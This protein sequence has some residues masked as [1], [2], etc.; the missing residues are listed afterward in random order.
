MASKLLGRLPA[1]AVPRYVEG[2]AYALPLAA[3]SA[4][5]VRLAAR[6]LDTGRRTALASVRARHTGT[7]PALCT[8]GLVRTSPSRRAYRGHSQNTS[9]V[10]VTGGNG[11]IYI[12]YAYV[13]TGSKA[14][15]TIGNR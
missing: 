6:P 13:Q 4:D 15:P 14:L 1:S 9:N 10:V 3:G 11:S 2:S 5:A 12:L 7:R 8:I